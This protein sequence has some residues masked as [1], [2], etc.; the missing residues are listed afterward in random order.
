MSAEREGDVSVGSHPLL[1]TPFSIR[2]GVE[3]KNRFVMLPHFT[4]LE[5]PRGEPTE[6]LCAY[7]AA[8]ARGGVGLIISGSQAIH[9]SGQMTP[10]YGRAWEKE[11]V[12]AYRRVVDAVHPHGTKIF[13]QLN[14][15]GHTTLFRHPKE[16]WAPSQ[17]PEPSS[18]YNTVEM[19]SDEIA[20]VVDGFAVSA[21]NMREAGFD[22]VEIKVGHDGLLRS[23]VSPFFNRREDLYGG[24]FENRMRLPIE[25]LAAVRQEVG[26]DWPISV[27]ICLHEYTPFGYELDYG[28]EVARALAATGYVDLFNSDAGSFSSFW[29]EIPPAAVPQ[30]AFNELNAALKRATDV[31]VIAFGRIKKPDDAERILRQGDADL[32][33]M[34]RQLIADPETPN[35]VRAGQL[36]N[37]RPCIGCNDGCIYQVMQENPVRCVQNPSAGRERSLGAAKS[38]SPSLSVVVV[39]GGPAG[40]KAAVTLAERGHRVTLFERESELGGLIRLA[41]R[42]PLHTEIGESTKQ[43]GQLAE[44]TGVDLY[45][46]TEASAKMIEALSPDAVVIATGS[47]PYLPGRVTADGTNTPIA[48]S[49]LFASMGGLVPGLDDTRVVTVDDVMTGSV[50]PGP[51][52]LLLDQNAHWEACGTAEYLLEQGRN[53]TYVTPLLTAGTDLE[54]SN[55]ALFYQ[56]VRPNGMQITVN[57]D[58]KEITCDAVVLIDVHTG[59]EQHLTH[60]HTVVMAIG[61]RSNDRLFHEL[62]GSCPVFRIGDCRAPRFLEH[63]ILEGDAIGRD[64]EVRI[65]ASSSG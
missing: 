21:C 40:L 22:G 51:N 58:L 20:A 5:T 56:R 60:I 30:L 28:L 57:T 15:G 38:A 53:V 6:D 23:F 62:S 63:A 16:L 1:W 37:I 17:M 31:P 2:R 48:T 26:A 61:R 39:G 10:F 55:A 24:S 47:R 64:L 32:I 45:L 4:G 8:R 29:M 50:T 12:P 11:A 35:K 34:A 65:A 14:H 19:G 18:R 59:E 54:P 43:L 25:V 36:D 41:A 3:V 7:Y 49:G 13:A 42:Q 27:R 46:E 44:Q 33:G 9:L 52:V